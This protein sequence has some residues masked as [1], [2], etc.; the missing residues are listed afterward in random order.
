MKGI[1]HLAKDNEFLLQYMTEKM[2]GAEGTKL[3]V[4][5][6]DMERVSSIFLRTLYVCICVLSE[7]E[8]LPH[9]R[10]VPLWGR[11]ERD[12]LHVLYGGIITEFQRFTR[13]LLALP[14]ILS[15]IYHP[16]EGLLNASVRS[17]KPEKRFIA[18]FLNTI[19]SFKF[20]VSN[21]TGD[22]NNFLENA[23]SIISLWNCP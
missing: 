10:T 12:D 16:L 19:D 11:Q 20:V 17:T 9:F 8:R 5:F 14:M 3:D 18:F 22:L 7:E 2:G 23:L 15:I 21:N 4:D 13:L 1:V 6:V